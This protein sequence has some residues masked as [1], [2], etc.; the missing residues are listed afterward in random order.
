MIKNSASNRCY[1]ENPSWY[2]Q[3]DLSHIRKLRDGQPI[4]DFDASDNCCLYVRTMKGMNFQDDS[5]SSLIDN[6]KDHCVLMIDL[7]SM[8]GA[9]EKDHY[10]DSWRTT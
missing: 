3:I 4:E 5:P 1:T 7:T 2:Q 8:Q 6:F 9:S 10:P